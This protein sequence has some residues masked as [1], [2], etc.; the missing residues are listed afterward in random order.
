MPDPVNYLQQLQQM[1]QQDIMGAFTQGFDRVNAMQKMQE[2]ETQRLKQQAMQEQM[3]ADLASLYR[4]PNPKAVAAMGLKYPQ[5]SEQFKRSYDQMTAEEQKARLAQLTP[6][7]ASMV[8]G[9]HDLAEAALLQQAEAARAA[10]NEREAEG[11]EKMAKLVKTDP[12]TAETTIALSLA[13]V[14]GGDKFAETF[15]KMGEERRAVALAPETQKKA[16]AEAESAAVKAKFAEA[17]AVKGLEK[18]GW[19]IKKIQEDI[20]IAKQNS[21]IAA[22]SASI[23]REANALKREEL[24]L[25]IEDAKLSRDQAIRAK[26][27]EAE[28]ELETITTSKSLLSEILDKK[29]RGDLESA[30]GAWRS[31]WVPGS[32]AK[33]MAGK[34]DQLQNIIASANLDK[35]KGA[36]SDKDIIF[37][38]NIGA[39]LDRAQDEKAFVK[40]L[41]RLQGV[42]D[43]SENKVRAKYGMPSSASMPKANA[44]PGA[45]AKS[46][47][48]LMKAL[49]G[50]GQ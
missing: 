28:T 2:A 18:S 8:N 30:T 33:T 27:A 11:A 6:A 25:K 38:K 36:M 31:S 9:R 42:M 43:K 26:A 20:S 14:M 4:D 12:K 46:P 48:E 15:S 19:D 7:Y 37:L 32:T 35:L 47:D 50:G 40:E 34:I 39:N 3:N 41:E 16:A 22:M 24:Q 44:A 21:R 23:S 17:D 1:P 29:N 10:G 45:G 49:F 5:L 13:G